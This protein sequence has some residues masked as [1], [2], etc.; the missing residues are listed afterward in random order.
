[1]G[2]LSELGPCNIVSE[3]ET[4]FNPYSW[5]SNA[6]IFFIDQPV[7]VGFS[8]ADFGDPVSSTEESAKDIAAFA[9]IFFETFTQYRGRAFH[10]SGESYAGR[11]LPVYASAII[12]QNKLLDAANLTTVNLKSVI[13]GNGATDFYHLFPSYY[14]MQCTP[15]TLA[16][17]QTIEACVRMKKAIPRCQAAM[18]ASCIDVW[19]HINCG[20]AFSFCSLELMGP[21][22]SLGLSSYDMT[23]DCTRTDIEC[24]PGTKIPEYLNQPHIRKELGI[25][26]GFGNYTDHSNIIGNAFGA[27]GDLFHQNQ[28]Y[29]AELLARNI[30][31]LIYAGTTDFI[32]NWLGNEKWTLN[33]EWFGQEDFVAQELEEWTIDGVAAGKM[34]SAHGLMFATVYGGGHLLPYDRPMESLTMLNRWLWKQEL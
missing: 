27:S 2:L 19:D 24:V 11:Y 7:G 5:N 32:C 15:T 4:E 21:Y 6:S 10:L 20:A 28:V 23:R 8:Y 30:S 13:I 3:T 17:L 34:R 33:M 9:A 26:A 18:K 14:E 31:V 22:Q 16:P 12:D 29:V 25:D 1:M